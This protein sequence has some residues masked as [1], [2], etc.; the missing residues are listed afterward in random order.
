MRTSP[1]RPIVATPLPILIAPLL[2][3]L[4]TPELKTRT[5]LLPL[6]PLF[7][8]LITTEPEVVVVPSPEDTISVPP[9]FMIDLPA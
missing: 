5:P 7:I 8:L 2:P 6:A 9:V 3:V 1:P 4:L